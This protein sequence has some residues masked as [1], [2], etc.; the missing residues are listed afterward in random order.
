MPE[1]LEKLAAENGKELRCDSVTKGGRHL[2]QNLSEGDENSEKIKSLANENVYDALFLQE[3]SFV[4]IVNPD[5]FLYGVQSLKDIVSAKRTILY[6]TWGRKEGSSK[7]EE[8]ALTS[9][10]MTKKL[11]DAYILVAK[12]TNSEISVVGKAFLNI[13][14][15]IPDIELYNKDLSHPSYV[16]SVVAAI[17]HYKVLYGEMPKSIASLQIDELPFEKIIKTVEDTIDEN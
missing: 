5:K 1:I 13:S 8:L 9:E 12:E 7:L 10:G 14:Q 6:S 2:Y 15:T 4:P 11:T 17:C 16:G 3:Q